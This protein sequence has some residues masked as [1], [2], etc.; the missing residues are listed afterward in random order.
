MWL[1]KLHQ[2][3]KPYLSMFWASPRRYFTGLC[4]Q[5]IPV[6]ND[7]HGE[8]WSSILLASCRTNK[9]NGRAFIWDIG[10]TGKDIQEELAHPSRA[11]VWKKG[12]AEGCSLLPFVLLRSRRTAGGRGT[13]ADSDCT[14]VPGSVAGTERVAVA[15]YLS[16]SRH[17][18]A[19]ILVQAVTSE[20]HYIVSCC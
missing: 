17:S 3:W 20:F 7:F 19:H 16:H 12:Q 14:R 11:T 2:Y 9:G 6:F 8:V 5:H 4:G 18:H 15:P 13:R 10:T 1:S